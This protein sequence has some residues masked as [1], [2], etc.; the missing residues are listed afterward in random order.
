[1]PSSISLSPAHSPVRVLL[2]RCS[3]RRAYSFARTSS[4]GIVLISPA[5]GSTPLPTRSCCSTED[6]ARALADPP[7]RSR[8]HPVPQPPGCDGVGL[9]KRAG[10]RVDDHPSAHDEDHADQGVLQAVRTAAS[11][12]GHEVHDPRIDNVEGIGD[13][14]IIRVHLSL[15]AY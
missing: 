11:R 7:E 14:L 1:M 12:A 8:L 3:L 15:L 4:Q 5:L 2:M 13:V 6:H 9:R 10:D